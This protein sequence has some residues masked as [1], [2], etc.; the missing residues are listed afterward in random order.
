[1]HSIVFAGFSATALAARIQN[2]SSKI[3]MTAD[4]GVRGGKTIPLKQTVDTAVAECPGV[5]TVLVQKRTGADVPM[6]SKDVDLNAAMAAASADCAPLAVDSEDPLFLLYT[7]GSTGTP[8]GLT[9]TSGGY[10]TY[11]AF[12]HKTIFDYQ[13]GDIYCCAAD[14]GWI[15]GHTYVVYGPLANGATT[16]LFE[17]VPTFPDPGRYWEMV[18]RLKVKQFYTAPTAIRLLIKSGDEWVKK[19]DLS[20][21]KLLASVGEPINPEA[22]N[23]YNDVV[24]GDRCPIMDTWWQTETGGIMMTPLPED[25]ASLKPGAAMKPF[26]GAEPVI[27]DTEGEP[28]EGNDVQG[29]LCF[30]QINPGMAR[31]IHGDH[32]RFKSV[33]YDDYPGY[34][35]TGDGCKRDADGDYWITGRVDDVINISGHRLGTA[36]VESALVE[37]PSVA[38]A[39]VVGFPHEIKGQGI[40]AYVTLKDGEDEDDAKVQELRAIVGELVGPFAKPDII[41]LAPGLPKTRSGKIMRRILRKVAADDY[42]DLGDT[43]TLNEPAVVDDIIAKHESLDR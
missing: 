33:Y 40:Y 16:V 39:A 38:E 7:S 17:S 42:G 10:I 31:S 11:A 43:S 2:A 41:H 27:M 15:T 1:V 12:T 34:Y 32:G 23:W 5:E 9:H 14:A 4:Q 30:K 19:Y 13:D 3:V 26:Y 6:N 28:M 36:E 8:K 25:K 37:H 29:N 35:F 22:W 24:G 21:L 20:S 18:E